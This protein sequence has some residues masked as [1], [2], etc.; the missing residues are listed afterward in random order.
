M[1][2]STSKTGFFQFGAG[3]TSSVNG[4]NKYDTAKT[5]FFN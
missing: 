3:T 1:K 4:D 5:A 2:Y